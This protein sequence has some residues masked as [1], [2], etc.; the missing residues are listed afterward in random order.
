MLLCRLANLINSSQK[1][2]GKANQQKKDS[3]FQQRKKNE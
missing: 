1:T 2:I 3:R